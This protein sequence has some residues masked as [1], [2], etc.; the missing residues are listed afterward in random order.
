M[1]GDGKF[2]SNHTNIQEQTPANPPA[3]NTLKIPF[4]S[5]KQ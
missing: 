2:F 1:I 5:A 3:I 4:S